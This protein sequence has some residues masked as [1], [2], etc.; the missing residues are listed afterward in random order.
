M[1]LSYQALLQAQRGMLRLQSTANMYMIY[2]MA[3]YLRDQVC[4]FMTQVLTTDRKC[5]IRIFK[6]KMKKEDAKEG[7]GSKKR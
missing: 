2:S 7:L 1:S 3:K 5:P 4:V 6:V